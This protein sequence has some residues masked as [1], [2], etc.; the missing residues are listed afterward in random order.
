MSLVAPVEPLRSCLERLGTKFL[1]AYI[2]HP[3]AL[4]D[5]PPHQPLNLMSVLTHWDDTHRSARIISQEDRQLHSSFARLAM[6]SARSVHAATRRAMRRIKLSRG[7]PVGSLRLWA[8]QRL[9]ALHK[10]LTTVGQDIEEDLQRK[11]FPVQVKY[12][13]TNGGG[14]ATY[15]THF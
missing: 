9:V 4:Q 3:R 12:C 14:F 2:Q 15:P 11:W 10:G 13:T 1:K 5:K 6:A 7:S 8:S